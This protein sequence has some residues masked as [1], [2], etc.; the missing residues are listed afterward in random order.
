M[1]F[2]EALFW[3]GITGFGTGLYFWVEASVKR[4]RSIGLTVLGALACA[5]SVYRHYHPEIPEIKLWVIL[6]ILTWVFL[7]YAVYISRFRRLPR[8]DEKTKEPRQN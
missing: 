1:P 6:L 7:G 8:T 5:Y 2:N 4:L 3:F